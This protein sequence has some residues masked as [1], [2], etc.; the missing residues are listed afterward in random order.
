MSI[1]GPRAHPILRAN[2]MH[3]LSIYIYDIRCFSMRTQR[4]PELGT[5]LTDAW[6]RPCV[7]ADVPH[8]LALETKENTGK[9]LL[10]YHSAVVLGQ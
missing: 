9:A 1:A 3:L 2:V 8:H 5:I 7:T 4:P 6:Q 10:M